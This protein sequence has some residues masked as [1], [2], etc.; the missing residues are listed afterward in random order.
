[1][2]KIAINWQGFNWQGGQRTIGEFI[3]VLGQQ[4]NEAVRRIFERELNADVDRMLGRGAYERG[5]S[6]TQP[7]S[8]G[9]CAK[10]GSKRRAGMV[11]NGYRE[12]HM[13]TA[14]WGE[15]VVSLP[16]VGCRCGGRVP[17]RFQLWQAYQRFWTDGGTTIGQLA[18]DGLSVRQLQVHVTNCLSSSVGLRTINEA[19][20]ALKQ[21]LATPVASVAPV[22]LLDAIWTKVLTPTGEYRTDQLSRRRSVKRKPKVAILIALA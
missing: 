18:T 8:Q 3:R 9:I 20:H 6:R 13:L 1:M 11:R 4:I 14:R 21:R 2:K 19:L 22:L 5:E 15:L 12:R 7:V 10:C 17:V 16:R